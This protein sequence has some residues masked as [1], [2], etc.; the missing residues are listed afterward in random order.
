MHTIAVDVRAPLSQRPDAD[1]NEGTSSDDDLARR[2][3]EQQRVIDAVTPF[4]ASLPARPLRR[5]GNVSGVTLLGGAV[6]SGLWSLLVLVDV[7][8]TDPGLQAGLLE[9]LPEGSEVTMFGSFGRIGTWPEA[10][11]G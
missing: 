4:L 5:F 1:G 2:Q 9:V 3:E 11:D 7:D 10:A 8:S 6:S